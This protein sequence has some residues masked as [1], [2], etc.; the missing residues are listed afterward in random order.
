[1]KPRKFNYKI[2]FINCEDEIQNVYF[3]D[4]WEAWDSIK[5]LQ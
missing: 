5:S 3:K 1:M 2:K 4:Y